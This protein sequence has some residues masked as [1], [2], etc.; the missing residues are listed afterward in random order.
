[1]THDDIRALVG[2]LDPGAEVSFLPDGHPEVIVGAVITEKGLA[3][4]MREVP[5]AQIAF[6]PTSPLWGGMPEA[7]R[8]SRPTGPSYKLDDLKEDGTGKPGRRPAGRGAH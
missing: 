1:M 8:A 4:L 7:M 5:D 2:R 6:S 3:E